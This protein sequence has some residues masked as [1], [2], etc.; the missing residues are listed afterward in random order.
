VS[1]TARSART[2]A[3]LAATALVLA[4]GALLAI[5]LTPNP[6]ANAAQ[7]GPAAEAPAEWVEPA[8]VEVDPFLAALVG[9]GTEVPAN[10]AELLLAADRVCEGLTA[11]VDLLT[12]QDGIAVEF[13]VGDEEARLFVNLAAGIHCIA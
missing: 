11:G 4:V 13:G 12:M 1:R 5:V 6:G 9:E 7:P 2:A 3:V 10:S 8:P